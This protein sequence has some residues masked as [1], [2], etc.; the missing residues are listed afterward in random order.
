MGRSSGTPAPQSRPEGGVASEVFTVGPRLSRVLWPLALVVGSL[1]LAAFSTRDLWGSGTLV[2]GDLPRF[3]VDASVFFDAYR[4]SWS[5]RGL[6][7]AFPSVTWVVVLGSML[8][9]VGGDGPLA[10]QLVMTLWIPVAC[11]G[12]AY[13]CRRL[14][15]TSWLLAAVGGLMYVLTPVSI[16]LFVGGAIGLIWSYALLP[17]VLI[18][19]EMLRSR[20]ASIAWFALPV[21]LLAATS[22]ELLAFGFLIAVVWL[23][24]GRGRESFLILAAVALGAAALATLPSLVGR[25]GIRLSSTLI[26]KMTVD[27]QYTYLEI[28]PLHLLR[29]A[30]NHGDPMEDLGYNAAA[31]WA[32]AGYLPIVALV[33]GMLLRHHGDLFVLR[34]V[35]LAS[36]VFGVLLGLSW[37]AR[38]QP[39]VFEEFTALFVFRNPGKLMMLLTAA[40]IPVSIYGIRR[41]FEFLPQ[42]RETLR[43]LVVGG[44]AIYL[45]AYEAQL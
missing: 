1:A 5:D 11:C 45:V 18:G 25:G 22:P 10:Q 2:F 8:Q 6:G 13:L 20:S 27:F 15:E 43:I 30:G 29:L 37:L 7:G 21:A 12:M 14:I 16:G 33:V 36:V 35:V 23:A 39:G 42:R 34:L 4:E 32:Y 38:S 41:L 31:T 28:T 19:A 44:V 17:F 9:V 26:E 24:I 40:V 3:P